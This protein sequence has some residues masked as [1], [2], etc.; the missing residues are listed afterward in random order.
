MPRTNLQTLELLTRYGCLCW[1][2]SRGAFYS[3][4]PRFICWTNT[5]LLRYRYSNWCDLVFM[6]TVCVTIRIFELAMLCVTKLKASLD[7]FI[8]SEQN[9]SIMPVNMTSMIVVVRNEPMER[10]D[11]LEEMCGRL[12][13]VETSAYC[14]SFDLWRG[15]LVELVHIVGY[16][17][18]KFNFYT[19]N[20]LWN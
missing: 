13:L 10:S 20:D 9:V 11:W 7:I 8:I 12:W 16:N 19:V 2:I 1:V 5:I 18:T 17:I 14:H 4:W 15:S 6:Q 3:F